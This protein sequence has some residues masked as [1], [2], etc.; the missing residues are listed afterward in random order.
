MQE[1]PVRDLALLLQGALSKN[2]DMMTVKFE[3]SYEGRCK[4]ARELKFDGRLVELQKRGTA[5]T[6]VRGK[7]RYTVQFARE[8]ILQFIAA[9]KYL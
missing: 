1:L 9:A 8:D 7:I 6:A 5:A 4:L 2:A 3:L